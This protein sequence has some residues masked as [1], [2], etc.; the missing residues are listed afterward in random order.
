MMGRLNHDQGQL[1]YSFCLEEVVPDDHLVREI[2]AALDLSWVHAELAP[3]YAKIGRPSIDPV[4][5]IRMLIIGYVF[6]IRSERALCRDVQVNFAYNFVRIHKTLRTTPAMAAK[7]TKRLWEIGDVVDVLEAWER[8]MAREFYVRRVVSGGPESWG[9]HSNLNDAM[10]KACELLK[11][12]G[13]AA[14]VSIEDDMGFV[15][16]GSGEVRIRCEQLGKS[17]S[18]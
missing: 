7:V 18:K 13:S 12:H 6:A 11:I 10:E 5:M 2:A 3:Y 17:Q 14:I 15:V 8:A 9:P 1:F 16:M 4:L